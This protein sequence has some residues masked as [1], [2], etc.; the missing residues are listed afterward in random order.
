MARGWPKTPRWAV[1]GILEG[2]FWKEPGRGRAA[3][4]G[5]LH[6]SGFLGTLVPAELLVNDAVF[7]G[8]KVMFHNSDAYLALSSLVMECF[9]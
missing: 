1:P 6:M 8:S 4:L 7:S 3:S 9:L 2:V 5:A